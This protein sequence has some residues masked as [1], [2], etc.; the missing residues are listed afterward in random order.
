MP[1]QSLI[2]DCGLAL[3]A[4]LAVAVQ[5]T[6]GRSVSGPLL[7]F[8]AVPVVAIMARYPLVLLRA[9]S[10][11]EIGLD[12]AV[13]IFLTFVTDQATATA[14]WSV[15]TL[16]TQMTMRK[17]LQ[18]RIFNTGVCMLSGAVAIHVTQAIV[19]EPSPPRPLELVAAVAAAVTYFVIDYTLSALAL[20]L[21]GSTTLRASLWD[22]QTPL[23][24]GVFLGVAS[25]GYVTSIIAFDHRWA[26]PLAI[27]PVGVLL[28]A[29]H[30]FARADQDRVR[31]RGLFDAATAAHHGSDPAEVLA[32]VLAQAQR[33]LRCPVVELLADRPRCPATLSVP[34]QLP[35]GDRWLMAAP[36]IT[37]EPYTVEEGQ[38]LAALAALAG[39]SMSRATLVRRMSHLATHDSLTGLS[40]RVQLRDRLTEAVAR[41][42]AGR[43][44][45]VLFCDLDGFKSVNDTLGHDVGDALLHAVGTRLSASVRPGDFLARLGGDEFA[46]VAEG[47]AETGDAVGIAERVLAAFREPFVVRGQCTRVGCSVGVALGGPG[48]DVAALLRDSDLAMYGAKSAGKGRWSLFHPAML[49]AQLE[50]A[51]V[52]AELREGIDRDELVLHHQP[53]VDLGTGAVVGFEALVR[54]Q[55]PVRGLLAPDAFVGIAE[56][57]GLITELGAWVARRAHLDAELIAAA[58][59]RPVSYS[60]NV[61]AQQLTAPG[62]VDL[63]SAGHTRTARLVVEITESALADGAAIP[64]LEQLRANGAQIAVDDF[65][66]GYSSLS[67][68][69]RLPVDIVKVDRSFVADVCHDDRAAGLVGVIVEM[70]RTL[71]VH[72]IAEGLEDDGQLHALRALGCT[73]AQG[74]LFAR[75]APLDDVLAAVADGTVVR[76]VPPAADVPLPHRI[77]RTTP[78][79]V[80]ARSDRGSH[81]E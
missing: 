76:R 69:R 50:R 36:R 77:R 66:T 25:L 59:G 62:I 15:A 24:F 41:I 63:L 16:L 9:Q 80:P 46:V 81:A 40:N 20:W 38:A 28:L 37:G 12:P 2:F 44:V 18:T 58:T 52:E 65:G 67:R 61:A 29:S 72:L 17:T 3:V 22:S 45:A 47:I 54:W 64:V 39:E 73:Y 7:L 75:P 10:G 51:T 74:F 31:A 79:P 8:A 4:M 6:M 33:I 42:S 60:V 19:A 11:I 14:V 32:A 71:D 26:L 55:H 27:V 56:E 1:R 23:S 21:L 43:A 34:I 78:A 30:A 35:E 13:L 48:A 5:L 68:L 57:V 49:A 53:V 70:A